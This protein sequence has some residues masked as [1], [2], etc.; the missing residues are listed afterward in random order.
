M[1]TKRRSGE[2]S[3]TKLSAITAG[4]APEGL[5][6]RSFLRRSGLAA[7]QRFFERNLKPWA[8]RFFGDLETAAAA[9]FYRNV[10]RLGRLF[11]EIEAQGFAMLA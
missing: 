7:E 1:L 10:G 5:D 9:R 11:M 6:R 8:A 4:L 2:P 3:R